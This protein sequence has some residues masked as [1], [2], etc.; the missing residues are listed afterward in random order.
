MNKQTYTGSRLVPQWLR[1]DMSYLKVPKTRGSLYLNISTS[2]ESSM[3]RRTRP[4]R[5]GWHRGLRHKSRQEI[6]VQVEKRMKARRVMRKCL[7]W[8]RFNLSSL[9][10]RRDQQLMLMALK[11]SR[12]R[13][14][15]EETGDYKG[16]LYSDSL[17][18]YLF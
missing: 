13:K 18:K 15:V 4:E 1:S 12:R 3:S 17:A 5:K 16:F 11:L 6:A 2:L 14:E 7:R 9:S 10:Q 8:R